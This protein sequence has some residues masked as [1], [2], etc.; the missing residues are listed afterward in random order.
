MNNTINSQV[1]YLAFVVAFCLA[2]NTC[3]AFDPGEPFK[4]S[5]KLQPNED[6]FSDFKVSPD[7]KTLV[8]RA[9]NTRGSEIDL[10]SVS[11]TGGVVRNLTI[12]TVEQNGNALNF[13]ISPDG[14]KVVYVSD[15]PRGHALRMVSIDGRVNRW[16]SAVQAIGLRAQISDFKISSDSSRVVYR[17]DQGISNNFRLI[18][19]M[20][21]APYS[22]IPV[23]VNLADG[24]SIEPD[25]EFVPGQNRVVYRGNVTKDNV[26]ELFASLTESAGNALKLNVALG[27][28]GNVEDGEFPQFKI[29]KKFSISPDGSYVVYHVDARINNVFDVFRMRNAP[30][31]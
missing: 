17:T 1:S 13:K 26:I 23:G 10:Y 11:T 30:K 12:L 28:G 25:F 16:L 22:R 18:R 27:P 3:L 5:H 8:Y 7:G 31:K 14:T 9:L 2:I 6:V 15:T 4:V 24:R 29:G 20:L 19:T 21:D